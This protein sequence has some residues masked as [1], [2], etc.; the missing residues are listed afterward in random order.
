MGDG[1]V[2]Q[3]LSKQFQLVASVSMMVESD[4]HPP[5]TEPVKKHT[6]TCPTCPSICGHIHNFAR[7]PGWV[8]TIFLVPVT[9]WR[10]RVDS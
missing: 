4:Q 2:H 6:N 3:S 7:A 9:F 8:C 10:L 1:D 5:Q